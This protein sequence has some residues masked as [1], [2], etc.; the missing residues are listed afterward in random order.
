MSC[1]D[2]LDNIDNDFGKPFDIENYLE[3]LPQ[4]DEDIQ[5]SFIVKPDIQMQRNISLEDFF[6]RSDL[7]LDVVP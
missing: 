5:D 3:N 6:T 2:G 1:C 7:L 4:S